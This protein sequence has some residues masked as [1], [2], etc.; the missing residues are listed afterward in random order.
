MESAQ[1]YA[2]CQK[3]VF[4]YCIEVFLL[5]MFVDR[6]VHMCFQVVTLAVYTYFMATLMGNQFLDPEKGYPKHEVDLVV[7][8]FTLL[9]VS[10]SWQE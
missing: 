8:I 6:S 9:Q 4:R 1:L 7:P 2:S 3:K 10:N 5:T